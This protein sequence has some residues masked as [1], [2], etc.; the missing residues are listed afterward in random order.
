MQKAAAMCLAAILIPYIS[1]LAWTGRVEGNTQRMEEAGK[2][3]V[4]DR[5]GTGT[6]VGLEEYLIGVT[7]VQIPADYGPEALKAQAIIARTYLCRQMEGKASIPE[8]ALDL[9]YLEQGQMEA[10]WGKEACLE[11]YKKFRDAVRETSGQVIRCDGEYINPLFHRLSAGK[12]RQGDSLH[13][14]LAPVES[15]GDVEGDGYLGVTIL[16]REEMAARLNSMADPPDVKA[17][18]VLESI[19]IIKKDGAGYV[20]SVQVGAKSYGGEELQ[21]ALGLPS[22]A[23]SFEA[24]ES[25][26]R[27]LSKGIGHGYG[28]DQYGACRMA[29]EGKTAEEILKFYYKNIVVDSE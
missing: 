24:Y 10:L 9:D 13:P 11:N 7:A 20:E 8:S 23:Y 2:T 17:E 3:I 21:Y 18:D 29:K 6:A 25:D 22:P 15:P 4:L 5:G 1:T 16:T 27:C 19:Q 28:F 14:Y 12:T 26:V